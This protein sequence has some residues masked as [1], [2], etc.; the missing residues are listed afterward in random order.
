[1]RANI[2]F[3]YMPNQKPILAPSV[4]SAHFERLSDE[5]YS[6]EEGGAEWIHLDIMDGRFVP[7]ITFGPFIIGAIKRCTSKFLD[8]HLM[9]VEP[10]KHIPAFAKAGCH[11][12][13]VHYETCHHL[14]AVISQIKSL[15]CKAGVSINPA[16]PVQL[17]EPILPLVDLVLIM[18]VNPG[19]GGQKLIPYTLDKLRW[20]QHW[21]QVNGGNGPLLQIDGGVKL[22]N[23]EQVMDS[24]ADVIVAGSAVFD[25][26]SPAQ[27]C[28]DFLQV[29]NKKNLV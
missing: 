21:N 20:L 18:S 4:L 8:A 28:R 6:V 29:M 17:L 13:T 22:D 25:T 3:P 27:A 15:G 9:I 11:G 5:L 26:P 23:I 16:T 10:E 12:I 1:M 19:F 24:G 7:N 2:Y 14:D